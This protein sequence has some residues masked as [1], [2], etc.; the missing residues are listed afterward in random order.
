MM[1]MT[2]AIQQRSRA[3]FLR[4]GGMRVLFP[5]GS[6]VNFRDDRVCA[7]IPMSMSEIFNPSSFN[8]VAIPMLHLTGTHDSSIFYGTLPRKR[9]V[10]FYSIPRSDQYLVVIRG[11]NHSTF[12]D[13]ERPGNRPAH[14][15][16]RASTLLFWKAYLKGDPEALRQLRD[17][18][19]ERYLAGAA[20]FREK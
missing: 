2:Q 15:V 6:V 4:F 19:L 7:G 13:E 3:G 1:Q 10:P 18:A 5:D 20:T 8:G 11:G 9:Q 12:S 14:D 16:I 17:G